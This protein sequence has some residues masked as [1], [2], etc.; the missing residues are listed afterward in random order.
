MNK[1]INAGLSLRPKT[2]ALTIASSMLLVSYAHAET[3]SEKR[4]QLPK[5]DVVG[6]GDE[7]VARQPGSVT[8]IDSEQLQLMQPRSTEDALR[9]VPGISIKGEEET[10]V[11]VNIGMRGL[12]A[13]SSKTL[14]LEDGVPV[15]P[16]LFVGNGRYFNPRIQRMESI[17]VLKG[18]ASLR[19]GP[20]TIGGVINYITKQPE[21]GVALSLRTGSWN[22]NEATLE[23]GAAA[24]SNEAVLVP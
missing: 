7:S 19:Y 23:L 13:D 9:R 6:S 22:T 16:G 11:V 8:L 5:I 24:P 3:S 17:E 21:P 20:S 15:A 14:I 1:P 12:P 10:A 2:L 18:A 4:V